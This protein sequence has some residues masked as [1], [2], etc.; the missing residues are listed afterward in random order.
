MTHIECRNDD[1]K[2]NNEETHECGKEKIYITTSL[3]CDDFEFR[4]FPDTN[5]QEVQ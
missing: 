4:E 1:C 5:M 2:Y 3:T